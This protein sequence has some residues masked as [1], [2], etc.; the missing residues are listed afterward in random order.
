MIIPLII[1]QMLAVLVGMADSIM[2]ASVGEAAVSGVSLVDNIMVL[3]INVRGMGQSAAALAEGFFRFRPS[4]MKQRRL[5]FLGVICTH[6]GSERHAALLRDAFAP[7]ERRHGIPLLGCL[8]RAGAPDIASR[9]LG[10]VQA[11]EAAEKLGLPCIWARS[12]PGRLVP[13]TAAA[14]ICDA[15]FYIIKERGDP[16]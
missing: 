14:A 3:L 7:L 2:V 16:E 12:L 1:E 5:K 11:Q 4:W 15:V 13:A 10:L 6:V 8:P 9:H